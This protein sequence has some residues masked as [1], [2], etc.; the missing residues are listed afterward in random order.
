LGAI[1]YGKA[2]PDPK[3]HGQVMRSF[4][5]TEWIKSQ[6]LEMQGIWSLGVFQK[7]LRTSLCPQDKVFSTRF[8]YK[9]KRKGGEFDICQVPSWYRVRT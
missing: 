9:I 4:M 7:N 5:C 1:K 8:H 2:T 6:N 3:H